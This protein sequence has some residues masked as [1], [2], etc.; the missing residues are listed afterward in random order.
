MNV[1][2]NIVNSQYFQRGSIRSFT[3]IYVYINVIY[4]CNKGRAG[5][6]GPGGQNKP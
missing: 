1:F 5:K 2:L 4:V 6:T 3:Q